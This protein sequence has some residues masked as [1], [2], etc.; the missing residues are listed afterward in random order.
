M[1][2]PESGCDNLRSPLVPGQVFHQGFHHFS[3][4]TL[5]RALCCGCRQ[6]VGPLEDF[7]EAELVQSDDDGANGLFGTYHK[8]FDRFA[9]GFGVGVKLEFE[10]GGGRDGYVFAV[11][12]RGDVSER[13]R[14]GKMLRLM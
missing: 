14:A 1:I 2:V 5:E 8:N 10:A 3:L 6:K 4:A 12:D 13:A 11:T 9:I 7:G